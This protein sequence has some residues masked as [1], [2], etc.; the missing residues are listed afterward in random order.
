MSSGNEGDDH[1]VITASADP[2][3]SAPVGCAQR[4]GGEAKT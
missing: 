1:W 2:S 4:V 3:A